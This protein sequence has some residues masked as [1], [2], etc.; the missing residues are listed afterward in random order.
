MPSLLR[1]KCS[2][3]DECVRRSM[4]VK[5][6]YILRLLISLRYCIKCFSLELSICLFIHVSRC[7]FFSSV[8]MRVW[9]I[10]GSRI[11]KHE[12]WTSAKEVRNNIYEGCCVNRK[13][14]SLWKYIYGFIN[15]TKFISVFIS[16]LPPVR[17]INWVLWVM[18]LLLLL[19]LFGVHKCT[20]VRSVVQWLYGAKP[21]W[22]RTC[23]RCF[24]HWTYTKQTVCPEPCV[25]LPQKRHSFGC[26]RSLVYR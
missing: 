14:L 24:R 1:I 6:L 26:A 19:L 23:Y 4:C 12:R 16:F 2:S 8:C 25:A 18:L 11:W 5:H 9:V 20:W 13:Q 15:A 17:C 22:L 10:F 7:S 21:I 3:L